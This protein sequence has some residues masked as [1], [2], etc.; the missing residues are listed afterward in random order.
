MAPALENTDVG[1]EL[2]RRQIPP[3]YELLDSAPSVDEYLSLRADSGLSPKTYDQAVLAIPGS[4]FFCHVRHKETGKAVGMCRI[5][6]D[7]GWYFHIADM[8]V[9]PEHQR[10]GLGDA[11][12][13]RIL[14]EI[15]NRSPPNRYVTL[16][17]DAPGR[18][19]YARH[20]FE[21]SMPHSLGMV[22]RL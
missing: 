17:G 1:T 4:W 9:L 6:A 8:A 19:L 12:L 11:L 3:E 20:G 15:S 13:R 7:G 16:M 21:D 10:R 14:D 18:K 2:Q 5:L 22:K